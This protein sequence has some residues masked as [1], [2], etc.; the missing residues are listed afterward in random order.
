MNYTIYFYLNSGGLCVDYFI[1][2]L[3]IIDYLGVYYDDG[4]V[5]LK[6]I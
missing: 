4:F 5:F 6:S 1:D 3:F 2:C